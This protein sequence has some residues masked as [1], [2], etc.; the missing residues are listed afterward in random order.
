[1]ESARR[2]ERERERGKGEGEGE[3]EIGEGES[4]REREMLIGTLIFLPT[5]ERA[6]EIRDPRWKRD[7]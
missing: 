6:R 7:R 1:M 2:C 4:K 5:T 3:G